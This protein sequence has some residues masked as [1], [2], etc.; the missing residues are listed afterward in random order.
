MAITLQGDSHFRRLLFRPFLTLSNFYMCLSSLQSSY[1]PLS[2]SVKFFRNAPRLPFPSLCQA[3]WMSSQ[4]PD[5]PR[6]ESFQPHRDS[7]HAHTTHSS[8]F[9][10]A[11]PLWLLPSTL[12]SH[13]YYFSCFYSGKTSRDE[14]FCCHAACC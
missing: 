2:H 1:P 13:H 7:F 5:M 10:H 11:G 14:I 3:L 9:I 4:C 6:S 12:L 8:N